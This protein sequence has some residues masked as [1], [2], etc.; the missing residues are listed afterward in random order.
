MQKPLQRTTLQTKKENRAQSTETG[1]RQSLI[2][3]DSE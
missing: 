2:Q 1:K 3:I